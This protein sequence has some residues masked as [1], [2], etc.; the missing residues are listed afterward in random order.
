M[1]IEGTRDELGREGRNFSY[2][3]LAKAMFGKSKLIASLILI[4]ATIPAPSG[5]RAERWTRKYI[6]SLPDSAFA[7]IE[8]TSHGKKV[9]HL[10]HHDHTGKLDLPHL[11]SA[12]AR[13]GQVKWVDPRNEAI[14][15]HHL[16]EH[17][18]EYK[19]QVLEK[20]KVHLPVDINEAPVEEL[21]KLPYIGEAKARA[22]IDYRTQR[23]SFQSIEEVI[24]V[25]GIG[26]KIFEEIRDYINV[27][28]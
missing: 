27:R 28:K 25:K 1:D 20:R 2:P 26:P 10:P 18:K 5:L 13:I 11:W 19:R 17:A 21:V 15:R 9:R 12:L 23:G 8:Y 22:I 6:N 3:S 4:V 16:E 7:S 14:A 24:K